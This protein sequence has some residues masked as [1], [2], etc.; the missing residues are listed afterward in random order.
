[1][2]AFVF[3]ETAL[4]ELKRFRLNHYITKWFTPVYSMACMT[5][6]HTLAGKIT[7]SS[8]SIPIAK[9]KWTAAVPLATAI[10]YFFPI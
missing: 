7:S 2:M 3:G 1:M 9:A 4:Q 10:P 5:P 6:G 8:L